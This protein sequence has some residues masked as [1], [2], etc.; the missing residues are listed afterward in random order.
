MVFHLRHE[1]GKAP[2]LQ[3]PHWFLENVVLFDEK[4]SKPSENFKCQNCGKEYRYKGNLKFHLKNECGKEPSLQCPHCPHRT[5]QKRYV[6]YNEF[7]EMGNF[8]CLKCERNYRHK[9]TLIYHL[10][11]ECGKEPSQQC[12]HC[13][14]R[15]KQKSNM[16]PKCNTP[17]A[18]YKVLE[19]YVKL[20]GVKNSIALTATLLRKHLA[21]ITQIC[22]LNEGGIEQLATFMGHTDRV[23]RGESPDDV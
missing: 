3:C 15:T 18:G 22:N 6:E 20:S 14:H 12:P 2:S 11:N 23:N 7:N 10:K 5:K 17:I 8:K 21:T 1:C 19:K 9:R 13:P 4:Y 16:R